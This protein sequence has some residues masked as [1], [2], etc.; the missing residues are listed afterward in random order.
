[1]FSNQIPAE[2][3]TNLNITRNTCLLN[4][5]SQGQN[6]D[7]KIQPNMKHTNHIETMYDLITRSGPHDLHDTH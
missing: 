3:V 2:I 5:I 4:Q 6:D 1:M 7:V